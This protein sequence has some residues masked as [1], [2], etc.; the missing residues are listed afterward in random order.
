MGHGPAGIVL[1]GGRSSRMGTPKAALE[2][3]GSTLLGRTLGVLARSVEGP[4]V[5]V[6]AP[7]QPLP[8]IPPQV[9]VVDDP[10]EGLG[11][12]Q[13]IAAGLAALAARAHIA[14]VCSTD[15]PFLH[16]AFVRRVL[17]AL[18]PDF[19]VVLPLARGYPQP[20]AA[21]YRVTLAPLIADLVAA[22]ERRLAFLFRHHRCRTFRLDGTAL[23]ADPGLAA[24]DPA[25]DSVVNVN[26]PEDYRTARCHPAPQVT[27][28]RYGALAS[29]DH[30]GPRTVRAATL[31]GAAAAV[32]LALDRH[33]IAALNGDQISRDGG[34]PL[35]SGDTIAFI[36]ADAGG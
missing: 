8:E 9:E 27:V 36:S 21:A 6:R 16:P 35:A 24:A 31:S 13:G 2:W 14:F 20:L 32:S 4:L 7:G 1:A 11:P 15:L 18:T 19:D 29:G 28:Q 3:H 23:L 26:S 5:V 22:G 25:L 30:H 12:L 17:R 33:V 10:E 34:L